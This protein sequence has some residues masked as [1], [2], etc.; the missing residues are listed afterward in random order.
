[1][2]VIEPSSF[3]SRDESCFFPLVYVV[4]VVGARLAES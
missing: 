4:E 1:M 3:V 2:L